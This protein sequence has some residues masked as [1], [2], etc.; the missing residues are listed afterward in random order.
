MTRGKRPRL[1][2]LLMTGRLLAPS[3]VYQFGA[4]SLFGWFVTL[5]WLV[6]FTFIP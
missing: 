1:P 6:P 5:N 3:R 2:L 4:A